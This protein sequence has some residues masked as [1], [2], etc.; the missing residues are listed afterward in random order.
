[1]VTTSETEKGR[2]QLPTP[3]PNDEEN[4]ATRAVAFPE[5]NAINEDKRTGGLRPKGPEM[6]RELTQ[7]DRELAAAGYEHLEGQKAKKSQTKAE[8]D[9]VDIQEHHLS[10]EELR[11]AHKTFF[12]TKDPAQSPGL[13]SEDAKARLARDGQNILTP[14]KKKSALRKVSPV[15]LGLLVSNQEKNTHSISTA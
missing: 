6:K 1:M 4:I 13:T 12:D 3:E 10:F 8:I 15:K 7:E 9:N 2:I 14:P 11:Q 5:D